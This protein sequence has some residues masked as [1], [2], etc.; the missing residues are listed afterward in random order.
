[1][2]SSA[3]RRASTSVRDTRP[4]EPQRG[5]KAPEGSRVAQRVA[6]MRRPPARGK[7]QAGAGGIDVFNWKCRRQHASPN[8]FDTEN[9]FQRRRGAR[10][11]PVIAL[12]D[13]HGGG[14]EKTA[15][16]AAASAESLAM[17]P[18]PWALR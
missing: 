10:Q 12:V 16:M 14:L 7:C 8:R 1:M 18:V 6:Q 3:L 5:L 2:T 11:C 13:E 9:R 17:V 4:A 15:P